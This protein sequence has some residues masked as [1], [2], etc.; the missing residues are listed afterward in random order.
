VNDTDRA[1]L[2][3]ERTWWKLPGGKEQAIH[4]RFGMTPTAYYQRLNALIDTPGAWET[5]PALVKRLQRIRSQRS[6]LRR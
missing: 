6:A 4:D 1:M 5:D 3:L 2:E